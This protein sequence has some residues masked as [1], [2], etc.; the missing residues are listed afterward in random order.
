VRVPSTGSPFCRWRIAPPLFILLAVLVIAAPARSDEGVALGDP[1]MAGAPPSVDPAANLPESATP[2][3]GSGVTPVFA[4][5]PFKNSQLG[6]GL[7][8]MVGLIHRFD[9]DTT[10]KPSTGALVGFYSDNKSWGVMGLELARLKKDTWRLTG[11]GAHFDLRY[12]FYGIGEAAGDAGVALPVD[13]A[14]TMAVGSGL[15]RVTHGLYAGAAVLWMRSDVA[16]V[17]T[18]GSGTAPTEDELKRIDLVAPGLQVEYDSRNDDYWPKRGSYA[19]LR[20]TF[21]TPGLGSEREFQR[22]ALGWSWYGTL[23]PDRLVLAANVNAAGVAGDAPFWAIPSVGA[24]SS[25]LRGYTQGRYRDKL[26]TTLQ[27]AL[28]GHTAGRWGANAFFGIAK[29]APSFDDLGDAE[30]LPAGGAGLRYQL[31]DKY[32]MHMRADYAWGKKEGILYLSVGEA[33]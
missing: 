29:V 6:W 10:L 14:L 19:L 3:S 17:D 26:V 7:T 8:L 1:R 18:S 24:G 20:S 2:P 13:Q 27:A 15:R 28:R 21:F 9:P 4:P 16:V 11:L 23:R 25:G 32:P 33:F 30:V 12:D 22:Y 31:T 5:I